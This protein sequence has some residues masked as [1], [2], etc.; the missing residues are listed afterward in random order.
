MDNFIYET[1]TKVYFGKDEELKTGKIIAGFAPKKVLLHYGGAS[2]EK[3]GL[4]ERIRKSLEE[5]NIAF[6]ELGGVV[7]N[8]QLSLVRKGIELCRRED[9]DFVL[10]VG[11]EG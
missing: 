1:P 10:A 2:A 9:V 6:V 5:E 11:G 4:L 7:P 3:S 8:P